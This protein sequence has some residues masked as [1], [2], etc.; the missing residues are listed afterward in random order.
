M[1]WRQ[2][3]LNHYDCLNAYTYYNWNQN[4]ECFCYI[5]WRCGNDMSCDGN[6]N[7]YKVN[8]Y[9]NLLTGAFARS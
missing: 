1:E 9:V 5:T 4:C 6:D 2:T 8:K 7:T 3:H